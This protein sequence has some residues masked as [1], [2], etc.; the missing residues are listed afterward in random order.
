M[1]HFQNKNRD[2][3]TTRAVAAAD[4]GPVRLDRLGYARA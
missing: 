4:R 1:P 2:I 3:G